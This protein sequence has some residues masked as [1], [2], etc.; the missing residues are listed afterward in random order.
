VDLPVVG[1]VTVDEPE[2]PPLPDVDGSVPDLPVPDVDL[3]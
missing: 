2:L 1:T 3:P